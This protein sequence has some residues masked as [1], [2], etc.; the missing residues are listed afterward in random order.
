VI[1]KKYEDYSERTNE[2][3]AKLSEDIRSILPQARIEHI[4]SSSIPGSLSKGDLDVFIGIDQSFFN[5]ALSLIKS[6]GFYDKEGTFRS[7]E[8]CMLVTDKF[9]YDV[10]I[11]LVSNGSEFED[12]LKFRDI[13]K[14]NKKLVEEYNE[15]KF[16]AQSSGENEYRQRKDI[17]ISRVLNS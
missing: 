14:M 2:L 1:L 7:N 11:Q 8:L 5:Q 10:A 9:N 16:L 3:F 15:I 4:G 13:L 17:F 6:L 12:F